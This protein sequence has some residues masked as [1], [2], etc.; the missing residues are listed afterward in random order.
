MFYRTNMF[1]YNDIDRI[2]KAAKQHGI[3]TTTNFRGV[4]LLGDKERILEVLDEC[5]DTYRFVV[6]GDIILVNCF[7]VRQ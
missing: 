5:F 2:E 7:S 1:E 4:S 3:D 6:D